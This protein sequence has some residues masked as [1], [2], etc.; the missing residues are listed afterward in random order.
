MKKIIILGSTGSIG[1]K[2]LNIISNDFYKYKI[3]LLSTHKNVSKLM[4]QAKQFRVKNVI[5]TDHKKFLN[6][7]KKYKNLEINIY[8]TFDIL[9]KRYKKHEIHYSMLSVVGIDG[10]KSIVNLIKISKN[11]AVVNKE[12]LI[13]GWNIIVKLLN[14]YKSNFIP[15]DSEHFSIKNLLK[16]YNTEDIKNIF[17]TASGGPFLNKKKN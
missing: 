3:E 13:C 6:A 5:I 2:T 8:N 14:K 10:L 4:K 7:Q 17:I 16:N 9:D 12:S 1:L 15:I 11:L